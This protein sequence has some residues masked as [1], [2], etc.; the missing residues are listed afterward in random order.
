MTTSTLPDHRTPEQRA[1]G[2][3]WLRREE[4]AGRVR[5]NALQFWRWCETPRCRRNHA[6]SGEPRA[7]F[8]RHWALFPD[9][10]KELIRGFLVAA[11]AGATKE[12]RVRAGEARRLAYLKMLE[13]KAARAAEQAS[14]PAAGADQPV[15]T[16]IR[17]L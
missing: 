6:C 3:R 7:C 9:D 8:E 12:E 13:A 1:A 16:R 14:P 17:R 2:E 15:E 5:C 10:V 11:H 4:A